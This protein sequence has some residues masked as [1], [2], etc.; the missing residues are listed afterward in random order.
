[1]KARGVALAL[2]SALLILTFPPLPAS[3]SVKGVQITQPQLEK[4]EFNP[5]PAFE[6]PVV[7]VNVTAG[8]VIRN[9]TLYWIAFN[10]TL[11]LP[12]NL[13]SYNRNLTSPFLTRGNVTTYR[14][15][16]NRFGNGTFVYGA[17]VAYE[18]NGTAT[19]SGIGE[20]YHVLTPPARPSLDFGLYVDDVDPR[21]LNITFYE[22]GSFHNPDTYTGLALYDALNSGFQINFGTPSSSYDWG[23]YALHAPDTSYQGV[24]RLFPF[25]HYN[26]T[27]DF[28]LPLYL[29]MSYVTINEQK[30][31]PGTAY[32]N[33]VGF[34]STSYKSYQ[35]V[36][37]WSIWSSVTYSPLLTMKNGT[38]I[39]SEIRIVILLSRASDFVNVLLV[40]T[41]A[42]YS[43]LG[44][45]VFLNGEQE[46][47]NRLIIYLNIFVF[48]FGF[49][50][51]IRNLASVPD[52]VGLTMIERL[53][54]ALIPCTAIFAILTMIGIRA[55]KSTFTDGVAAALAIIVVYNLTSFTQPVYKFIASETG[56]RWVSNQ[57]AYGL[58]DFN[59][60]GFYGVTILLALSLGF[61]II[62]I[63][64]TWRHRGEMWLLPRR[65]KWWLTRDII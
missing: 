56:G 30:M 42:M 5:I 54:F 65:M 38:I 16:M 43:L 15:T 51:G 26:Y 62:S 64:W 34:S 10:G 14:I 7:W 20:I 22:Q 11:T 1:M 32:V 35:D 28:K 24:P 63:L 21:F 61:I 9:V 48:G 45:S 44:A 8:E 19:S 13:S 59:D 25:D 36:S 60:L 6:S 17:A 31:F 39:P 33:Y 49:F 40:T 57:F 3:A 29:N 46:L 55:K 12:Q 50:I 2:V 37:Q 53:G 58:F 27:L 23:V 52:I 4:T 47:R 18:P 41:L